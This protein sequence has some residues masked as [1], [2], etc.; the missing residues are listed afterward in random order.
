MAE[1]QN[2]RLMERDIQVILDVY[3][4]RYLSV[5]Q[6]MALRFQSIQTARRRLRVLTA[7]GHLQGFTA[8]GIPER[9][10]HLT[11]HG[12]KTVAS[13]LELPLGS[14]KWG[15]G[16]KVPKDYYFLKH[17]LIV[18]FGEVLFAI[19]IAEVYPDTTCRQVGTGRRIDLARREIWRRPTAV[20]D[21]HATIGAENHL[22]CAAG[23]N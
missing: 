9:I 4:H 23:V 22:F 10:Y 20:G 15:K 5:S 6:I 1:S 18:D 11:S 16:A 7:S 2:C 14:L 13:Y 19:A 8:P 17:F 3:K 12:A 21:V